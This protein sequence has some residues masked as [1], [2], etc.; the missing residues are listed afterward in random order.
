MREG[1]GAFTATGRQQTQLRESGD[2]SAVEGRK[3]FLKNGRT[4]EKRAW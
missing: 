1:W 4:E 3:K 2:R